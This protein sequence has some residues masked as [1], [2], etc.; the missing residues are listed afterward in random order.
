MR[1]HV[2]KHDLVI[3][4]G[5][6]AGLA[7]AVSAKENGITDILILERDKELGGILNQCIHNGF[8]LHTF[9]EE[10]TGPEYA[11][12]F[13]V[14][15][16]EKQIACEL[17]AMVIDIAAWDDEGESCKLITVTSRQKGLKQIKAKA[18]I[19]AM[20]CRER[21]RGSLNTPGYRPAGIYSAGTA[22]RLVNMEGFMPGREVVILGSGDIGLIMARRM[23]LEGATVKLVAELMPYSGGLKRNIVQCLDDFGIPLKLSHTVI[24]IDGR[25]RVKGVTIAQVDENR[26]PVP[27]TEEYIPCDTLL[28]SVGLIPENELSGKLGVK[29][30]RMTNGPSVNESLETSVA[31]VFACGNVL[32]VHDL[33]DYVSEESAL[34][35]VSAANYLKRSE[36]ERAGQ[37]SPPVE[38]IA[39]NG[40]RYTVPVRISPERMEEMLPLRF[41]VGNVY[42]DSY[43]SVYLDEERIMHRK[44]NVLAPGEMETVLLRRGQLLEKQGLKIITIKIEEA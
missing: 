2:E 16:A 10:L 30:E 15:A 37:P 12:R 8:G 9:K 19:F 41:R 38:V 21:A 23:T 33:V 36:A 17:N 34:A 40:V 39:G 35:G 32:H 20:G 26:N 24:D 25:K 6:P 14:L 28:L 7:A 5:G 43:I 22:Q 18:V 44:K 31:G 11:Q 13:I 4:G 27:G 3:I 29:M 42:K 1:E